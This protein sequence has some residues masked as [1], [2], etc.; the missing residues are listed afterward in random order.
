MPSVAVGD[1]TRLFEHGFVRLDGAMASDLS[2]VNSAR[3][4][5]AKRK[6]AMDDSDA[7]LIRFLMRD[8]HGTPFEHNAFRFHIR[9]PLFVAREWF[10]HRVGC[11]TGDTT[12]TF[13]NVNGSASARLSKTME[14][15]WLMWSRGERNGQ[16]LRPEQ[17]AEIELLAAAGNSGRAIRRATGLGY[18][19]VARHLSG[20][21]NAYRDA[22]W[23]LRGMRLRVL[24]E[25]TRE[26]ETGHVDAVFEKGIQPVY[27]VTLA[28]GRQVTATDDHR[29]LTDRGWMTLRDAVGLQGAGPSA[30]TTRTC[31][32]L[33]NGIPVYQDRA[34]MKAQRDRQ[35]SVQEIADAAGC[36]YHT[37]RAWLRRHGLQ[38]EPHERSF[39]PG[40]TPWNVGVTGYRLN[41]RWSEEQKNAIRAAR[42]GERSNFWRGGVSSE[43]ASIGRW[44]TEQAPKIHL[45]YDYT[46]Q[47]QDCGKRGGRLHAH[48]IVPVWLDPTLARDIGNLVTVCD[49]CH[50]RIHRTLR[51]ELALLAEL[52]RHSGRAQ[53]IGDLPVRKGMKLTAHAVPVIAVEYGGLQ[54]TYDLS[55]DGR[56]HNLVANGIVVHNSFNEE[57]AR[58]HELEGHFYVPA[59]EDVRSQVGK[60]GAYTFEP[61][62]PETAERLR[63]DLT[64]FYERTYG[65]YRELIEQG[66]AK[67]LA[68]S[69]LPMGTFTQFFWTVNARSLMNFLS[70]RNAETAQYEIR[71]Y[72]QA[73]EP[74]FAELMPVTYE[75]FVANQRVAP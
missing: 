36:S 38:F 30:T 48:H 74:F 28:D 25:E 8:R 67:E 56:W 23:R 27:R 73:I 14:E 43:R 50:R 63:A 29:L 72:A 32:L 42:S 31:R 39:P 44:T 75:A 41:R 11:L 20:E 2:V 65:L 70:L 9:C 26:F 71:C 62:D 57:S 7:G 34:W 45:Q 52:G 40:H 69:V 37:I 5:F 24:N 10:R 18:R 60:P 15:L 13:V 66:I 64:D 55:V 53:D 6:E 16:G 51:G 49:E 22:R 61:V 58:Y 17:A 33:V 12:V 19:S 47:V 35:L 1:E 68:R 59:A 46:C 21:G 4:S 3:V 54:Q